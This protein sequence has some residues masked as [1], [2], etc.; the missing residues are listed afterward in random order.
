MAFIEEGEGRGIARRRKSGP[1]GT[2]S[3]GKAVTLGFASSIGG[4]DEH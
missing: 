3:G 1:D 2:G 4:Q